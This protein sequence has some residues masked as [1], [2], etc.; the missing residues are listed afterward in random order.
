MT[1][2]RPSANVTIKEKA[3]V[4]VIIGIGHDLSAVHRVAEMLEGKIAERFI[5]RILTESERAIAATYRG[6][7]LH[8]YVAGRFAAKESVSK[9]FGCGIGTCLGFQDIDIIRDEVGKPS[10]KLSDGA[11][12]RL[13]MDPNTVR[14]HI[15]IT[16]ERDIASAFAVVER[17]I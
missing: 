2:S 17:I 3:G 15:T 1:T 8:Q 4:R 16:H 11:W 6:A 5:L 13:K 10:C 14:I 9:A 12:Q 7:R